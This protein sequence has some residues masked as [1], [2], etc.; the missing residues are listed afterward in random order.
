MD[1]FFSLNFKLICYLLLLFFSI[2]I[3]KSSNYMVISGNIKIYVSLFF[4]FNAICSE[5]LLVYKQGIIM[6]YNYLNLLLLIS[7]SKIVKRK[8]V[9]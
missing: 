2:I 1:L 4:I 9:L 7:L 8:Y 3:L 6:N 5:G